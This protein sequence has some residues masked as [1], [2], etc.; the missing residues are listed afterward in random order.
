MPLPANL[1]VR[2]MSYF[3]IILDEEKND[4]RES[5]IREINTAAATTKVLIIPTNEELEIAQQAYTLLR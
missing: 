4:K 5:G 3:G 1:S 2:D